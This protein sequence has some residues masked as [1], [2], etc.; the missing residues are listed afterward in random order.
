MF[1]RDLIK[2]FLGL[3]GLGAAP[4]LNSLSSNFNKVNLGGNIYCI[5]DNDVISIEYSDGSKEQYKNGKLHR[6]GGLHAYEHPDRC[7]GSICKE[8]YKDGK[9]H[10]DGDFPAVIH[11]DDFKSQ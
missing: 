6:D 2:G 1:R 5:K 8:W 7:Y 3:V 10:R 4:N 11:S 9:R